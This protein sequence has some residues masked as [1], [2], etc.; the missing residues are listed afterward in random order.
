VPHWQN[1][2]T[3]RKENNVLNPDKMKKLESNT[4]FHHLT[5]RAK[6]EKEKRR[7]QALQRENLL[8][9]YEN[10]LCTAKFVQIGVLMS[11]IYLLH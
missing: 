2:L 3:K 7:K 6:I 1:S 8:S 9:K 10:Y 5:P 11:I 4:L